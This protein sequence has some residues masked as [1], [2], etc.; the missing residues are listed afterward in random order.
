VKYIF[1]FPSCEKE[2]LNWDRDKKHRFD[3][4]GIFKLN[5]IDEFS[6]AVLFGA[7]EK[8]A[9]FAKTSK[10]KVQWKR[11]L[12]KQLSTPKKKKSFSNCRS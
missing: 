1:S 5:F 11:K 8:R 4:N 10:G 12:N 6:K 7:K 9:E 3:Q 2:T